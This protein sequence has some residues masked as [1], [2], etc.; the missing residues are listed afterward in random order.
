[1][2]KKLWILS[3]LGSFVTLPALLGV[4]EGASDE[5]IEEDR[6]AISVLQVPKG[7]TVS[8]FANGAQVTNP[9]ALDIDK[10]GRVYVAET[11]RFNRGTAE[12]RS[13]S[14]MLEDD[15]Q[16][17]TLEDRLAMYEKWAWR[18]EGG[19]EWF[20]SRE[21]QIKLLTDT[22][23]DGRADKTSVFAT[24][25]E[26]LDG[27][28]AGV[29]PWG[30]EVWVTCIPHLWRLRD[31]DGDGVAEETEKVHT[32]FGVRAS[33]FGHDLHGLTI[34]PD[35]R[36]YFSL[37]DRGYDVT[38]EDGSVLAGPE[39][40][41]VF[42]CRRDGSQLEV[43]HRGMRNP[44]E[45][46]FDEWG[47]LFAGDNNC[48]KGDDSRL[49]YVVDGGDSGWR[50]HY[51]SVPGDYRG[52]PWMAEGMWSLEDE[53][54]PVWLTP[55]AGYI[56]S[57]PSGLAYSSVGA[58]PEALRNRFFHCNY[59]GNRGVET[60]RT[61]PA[62]AGFRLV[63]YESFLGSARIA[64]GAFGYDGQFYAAEFSGSPWAFEDTG[65][66][67]TISD[68]KQ[69]EAA[70][71]LKVLAAK[72][73]SAFDDQSL[74]DL[75]SH[76]D[77]RLRLRAQDE[78]VTR[79][80]TTEFAALASHQA[81][82]LLQRVHAIWG[83]WQVG[84]NGS[85]TP[86]LT[87][88]LNEPEAEIRAQAWRV[89]GDLHREVGSGALREGLDDESLR[90]KYFVVRAIGRT[91][92]S[93]LTPDLLSLGEAT[94]DR[95]IQQAVATALE[96][97]GDAEVMIQLTNSESRALRM[98]A[99]LTLRRMQHPA[100]KAFIADTDDGIALE[101]ARA[102]HDL[103][104]AGGERE[105]AQASERAS[106][107]QTA[108]RLPMLRRA[109]TAN[110]EVGD[111]AAATRLIDL[112]LGDEDKTVRR[113]ALEAL[114]SWGEEVK[115]DPVTGEWRPI[116]PGDKAAARRVTLEYTDQLFHEDQRENWAAAFRV[117][118]GLEIAVSNQTLTQI[119]ADPSATAEVQV[120]AFE[121]LVGQAPEQATKIAPELLARPKQDLGLIIAIHSFLA[122]SDPESAVPFLAGLATD[123]S[124]SIP[125]RQSAIKTL[126]A[127]ALPQAHD[128]L[129]P[130]FNAWR[131][132]RIARP[133][134]MEISEAAT[135]YGEVGADE[136]DIT[137]RV[138]YGGKASLGR[139][140]F[141]NHQVAQ[142]FRC[143]IIGNDK[144]A[145][146][147]GPDLKG[148]ASRLPLEDI[149]EALVEPGARIAP[150]YGMVLVTLSDGSTVAGTLRSETPMHLE[151]GVGDDPPVKI[152]IADIASRSATASAMPPLGMILEKHDL[153]NLI[154]FLSTQRIPGQPAPKKK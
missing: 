57:G 22:D 83:L 68:P 12:N 7:F 134:L 117:C 94:P 82:P 78:L 9:V 85:E 3:A 110:R 89:L 62:G 20:T 72:D 4:D 38:L 8:L 56:G 107:I 93:E 103:G 32:G 26:T 105:L 153:R 30:D 147:A 92:A 121:Q 43:I 66:I 54:A 44:Q 142:C 24:F 75:L 69:S 39:Q 77:Q 128:A 79:G 106:E 19:M 63:E 124:T 67:Y 118:E 17:R 116:A 81:A 109:I 144:G 14:F 25:G 15:L 40:G 64:D 120:P 152:A 21:D 53:L 60:F 122:N 88:L 18:L 5:V 135:A 61:E 58:W 115:R 131:A 59:S 113:L 87:E 50:M 33:F 98:I 46:A 41:A 48:D 80:K 45:L 76:E 125:E 31:A 70:A 27:L 65:R 143:H 51:Q 126:A 111:E 137:Q 28:A 100:V 114:E 36:L 136:E 102:I 101:A 10:D 6:A 139:E 47:N 73:F 141:Y 29:L 132:E 96:R 123:K 129:R 55:S 16:V 11:Y 1:M 112:A 108:M 99:L 148:I 13:Q 138:L 150:G 86:G 97:I 104:I 95:L 130:L 34:G 133:L 140:I 146:D 37:G 74:L 42:R 91:K 49:I 119:L 23:A 149:H 127:L 90:V 151:I 154:A 145:G 2:S 84:L 35:N 52:G 71:E